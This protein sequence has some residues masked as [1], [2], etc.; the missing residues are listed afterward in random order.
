MKEILLTQGQRT[1]VDDEDY[2]FLNGFK[3]SA[4]WFHNV[5][6]Y[7]AIRNSPQIGGKRSV[8]LMARVIMQAQKN[9]QV[10]HRNHDTLDNRRE[11]LRLCTNAENSMNRRKHL[12][13]S[14]GYKGVSWDKANDRWV[15]QIY[16]NHRHLEFRR[17]TDPIEAAKAY[18]AAAT[19]YFGD[20]ALLNFPQKG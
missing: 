13:N 15:M 18:D 20:F 7:C 2:D 3:W 4:I 17:F 12:D 10:D 9:Q 5:K 8:M 14:S 11:N 1:L 16:Q 6:N 19:K